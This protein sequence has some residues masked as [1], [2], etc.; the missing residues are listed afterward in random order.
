MEEDKHMVDIPTVVQFPLPEEEHNEEEHNRRVMEAAT[1]LA[2]PNRVPGEW[3]LWLKAKAEELGIEPDVLAELVE[4][5]IKDREQKTREAQAAERLQEARAKRLHLSER[6]R[7]RD[8]DKA[9]KEAEREQ[10]KAEKEA[11]RKGKEKTKAFN[12]LLKLPV[13]QHEEGIAKLAT[14]LG[15]D[16][17]VLRQEFKDF[18]GIADGF[19]IASDDDIEPWPEPVDAAE[20]L[21]GISAKPSK[22]IVL[23]PHQNHCGDAVGGAGMGSQRD[24]DLLANLDGD[25]G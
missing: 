23:R 17:A 5:Q 1:R 13:D 7:K 16:L 9:E 25:L 3:K 19:S 2:N 14:R 12:N 24:C 21:Q 6:D 20:L 18:V 8:D 4:A 11:E 15:E 22:H 10:Q